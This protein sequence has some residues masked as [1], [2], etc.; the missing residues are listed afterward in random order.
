M[1]FDKRRANLSRIKELREGTQKNRPY[2]PV[3][4]E[5]TISDFFPSNCPED[6]PVFLSLPFVFVCISGAAAGVMLIQH[7]STIFS[8]STS[9]SF[10]SYF[11]P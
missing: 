1:S 3:R 7:L 6:L 10:S 4:Y 8:A 9:S 11:L 2:V 5:L